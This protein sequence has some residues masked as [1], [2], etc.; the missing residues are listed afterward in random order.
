MSNKGFT[1]IEITVSISVFIILTILIGDIFIM[2]NR[3]KTNKS[4]L[5]ELI[6]NSRVALDRI[7][8]E[9]R[10]ASELITDISTSS[11]SHEIEFQDGHDLSKITYIKYSLS[12]TDLVRE[13]T[14]YFFSTDTSTYVYQD[15]INEFGNPP[16]AS[17]TTQVVGEYFDSLDITNNNGLLNLDLTLTKAKTEFNINTDVYIRN[18]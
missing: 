7:S 6:Q 4:N 3:L 17:S 16:T 11:P 12:N 15:A 9:T 14:F 5:A 8:R 13:E 18:W 10:Q 1:L 2:S